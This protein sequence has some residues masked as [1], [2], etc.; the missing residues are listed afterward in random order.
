[1]KNFSELPL[2][3]QLMSN[4]AKQNFTEPTP[5]QCQAIEPALAG[6]DL[7]A[8]AQTGTG[9][10]LAFVLPTVQMLLNQG[11]QPGI[12]CVILTPTRELALQIT[13]AIGKIA[14]GTGIHAAVAVGGMN[15]RVQLKQIRAGAAIV[16]AE[17]VVILGDFLVD[18]GALDGNRN[19]RDVDGLGAV[20]GEDAAVD[21]V[22]GGGWDL[23]L[24]GGDELHAGVVE[25]EGAVAVI[26]DDDADGQQAVVDVGQAEEGAKLGVVAGIGGDGDVLVGVGVER[27]VGVGGLGRRSRLVIG[28]ADDRGRE[29]D[30]SGKGPRSSGGG[31]CGG[32]LRFARIWGIAVRVHAGLIIIFADAGGTSKEFPTVFRAGMES[33]VIDRKSTPLNS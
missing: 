2:S 19:E 6:R 13:E 28:G 21:V 22:F 30:Q 11:P 23:L 29:A 15:E 32:R 16:E 17:V 10:T 12:R 33:V 25:R 3:A 7:V 9:K 4:L 20:V 18:R 24:V 26:G 31:D 1:M 5:I 27:G 14:R 8:T